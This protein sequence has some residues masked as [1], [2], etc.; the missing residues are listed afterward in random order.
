MKFSANPEAWYHLGYFI[1]TSI[2]KKSVLTP[3]FETTL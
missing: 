2:K 3:Y 1:T